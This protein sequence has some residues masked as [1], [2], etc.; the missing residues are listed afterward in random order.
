[1]DSRRGIVF[2]TSVATHGHNSR[3][4]RIIF[5]QRHSSPSPSRVR[6]CSRP[7]PSLPSDGGGGRPPPPPTAL[8]ARGAASPPT[9][10]GAALPYPRRWRRPSTFLASAAA[11]LEAHTTL[12]V[13]NSRVTQ[14]RHGQAIAGCGPLQR[15]G[16]HTVALRPAASPFPTCHCGFGSADGGRQGASM[17]PPSSSHND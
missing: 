3:D 15:R 1:M 6:P 14:R 12:P 4:D 7:R 16:P 9:L 13:T 2:R 5:Q 10:G 11:P 17:A 8:A